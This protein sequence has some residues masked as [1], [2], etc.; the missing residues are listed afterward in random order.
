M[1]YTY[2]MVKTFVFGLLS[3][4]GVDDCTLYPYTDYC[5]QCVDC[6]DAYVAD[7][8]EEGETIIE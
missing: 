1:I 7:V 3:Q 8:P 5:L 6:L 4:L 2:Y